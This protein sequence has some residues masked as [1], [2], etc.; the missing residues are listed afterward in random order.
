MTARVFTVV[1]QKGGAGKTTTALALGSALAR[2]HGK[3]VLLVDADPQAS[4]TIAAGIEGTDAPTLAAILDGATADPIRLGSFEGAGSLDVIPSTED[5]AI[6]QSKVKRLDAIRR[7][8]EPI[9][10]GYDYVLL[11]SPPTLSAIT[12]NCIAMAN[13]AIIPALPNY[14]HIR[15]IE[16]VLATIDEMNASG[17]KVKRA[18]VL[19][20]QADNTRVARESMESTRE[21][22]DVFNT[23]IRRNV[24]IAEAQGV[25]V[26]LY[27]LYP[28]SNAAT[29]YKALADEIDS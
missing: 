13:E 25:G 11:D 27:D 14:L 20:T 12:L 2:Y 23:V 15:G 17:A 7:A 1:N 6:S 4:L 19:F 18:R 5:L 8:L 24:A 22:T 21:G 10:A 9:A 28:R 26:D 29:D 3:R 16:N